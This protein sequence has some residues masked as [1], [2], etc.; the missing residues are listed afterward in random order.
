MKK[1]EYC[2]KEHDGSF[3]SGR[4]C[5]KKCAR[6]FSTKA[7]R[8]EINK[9]V[10]KK[11]KKEKH[12][13]SCNTKISGKG[14]YCKICKRYVNNKI[15][16]RKL[17]IRENNLQ[18]ANKK[19][20]NILYK[21][22]FI[23][24]LPKSKIQE[25]YGILSNTLYYF[26]KKNNVKLRTLSEATITA[27][28]EGRSKINE[29]HN[30]YNQG[31]HKTW[32]NRM[33]YYRSSYELDYAKELDKKRIKYFTEHLKIKYYDSQKK[34]IRIAIPDFYIEK[35][36]CL[37]EIKSNYTYDKT[38]MK[39]KIKKY[40]NLGYNVKLILDHEEIKI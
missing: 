25:K 30:Q 37:I 4:F 26:F 12:C 28:E 33:I 15:L 18:I 8:K 13:I 23:K 19:A 24:K 38:N 14:N 5:S 21:E 9:K 39:D 17:N 32:D 11:L 6:G 3:G 2:K 35:D 27:L 1:C 10:S 29:V 31:C 34:K 7:K 36:N 20:L 40:K 16:F 22:Y